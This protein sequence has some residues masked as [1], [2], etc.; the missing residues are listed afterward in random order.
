MI[1]RGTHP[2]TH[3]ELETLKM[4]DWPLQHRLETRQRSPVGDESE[5]RSEATTLIK[6]GGS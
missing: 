1:A 5:L 4:I 2:H 3:T 6:P